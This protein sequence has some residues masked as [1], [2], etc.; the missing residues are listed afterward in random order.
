[1]LICDGVQK[2]VQLGH[3]V[4]SPDR[5]VVFVGGVAEALEN[6]VDLGQVAARLDAEFRIYLDTVQN[7]SWLELE[8]ANDVLHTVDFLYVEKVSVQTGH[9]SWTPHAIISC[10]WVELKIL[11]K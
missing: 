6:G 9:G 5:G 7:L 3:R 1:V 2:T 4:E 10:K 8:Q 11:K